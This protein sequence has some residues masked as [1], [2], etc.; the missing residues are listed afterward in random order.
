M[1]RP[2]EAELLRLFENAPLGMYQSTVEGRFVFVN[3]ALVRMLGYDSE[4]EVLELNLERDVYVDPADR[5]RV[6]RRSGPVDVIAGVEATWKTRDG[7]EI[8][9]LLYSSA[10]RDDDGTITG[11]EGSAADITRQRANERRTERAERLESL[12]VLAGGVA[13]DFNNLLHAVLGNIDLALRDLPEAFAVRGAIA[14]ARI[15]AARASD[16]TDQLLAYAGRGEITADEVDINEMVGEVSDVLKVSV[17]QRA[18]LNISLAPDVGY[19]LADPGQIMQVVHNLVANASDA[20]A[21]NAGLI[22]L[23]TSAIDTDIELDV[24]YPRGPLEPGHYVCIEVTDDGCGM[25][26][27]TREHI[28]EP[29]FTTKITGHGLGLAA[30]AGI[31]RRHGGGIRIVSEPNEGTTF[32]VFLPATPAPPAEPTDEGPAVRVMPAG[33]RVLVV[34]DEE[35]IRDVAEQ[36]LGELGF[37]ARGADGGQQ[38]LE[39]LGAEGDATELV[40]LDMTMPDMSGEEV[41]G[42]IRE[43]R[44]EV[45]IVLC[46]GY[47]IDVAKRFAGRGLAGF[48]RKPFKFE[49]LEDMLRQAFGDGLS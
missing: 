12:G 27:H 37:T 41:F 34:D 11:Y 1:S 29:F 25:D 26:A 23:R 9:V 36:M 5:D 3:R 7:G 21:T 14:N 22:T 33:A 39:V 45:R 8:I 20:L 49:T 15:A 44:P 24:A 2:G 38:A 31:I 10:V 19:V 48:L 46:S 35:L 4:Q 43:L 28:F 32:K 16:L 17:S 42:K 6:I 47:E 18:I 40:L 30:V 13:H